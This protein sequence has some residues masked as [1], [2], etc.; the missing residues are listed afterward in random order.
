M[1]IYVVPNVP[2]TPTYG[3][4]GGVG[5][6]GFERNPLTGKVNRDPDT[7]KPVVALGKDA[8]DDLD[9]CFYRHDV[10]YQN[11]DDGLATRRDVLIADLKLIQE[12]TRLDPTSPGYPTDAYALAYMD[13]VK[14]AF[15]LKLI[16]D[17][18]RLDNLND[19]EIN[20][21]WNRCVKNYPNDWV[22]PL[23]DAHKTND[24][25]RDLFNTA[26]VTPSPIILDLD[27][28]GIETTSLTAGA[29]F[30]HDGNGFAEQT[31]W[32]SSDDGILVM[33]RNNNGTIDNGKE[34]FGDQTIL[35]NGARAANGF[36]ALAELD[37]N[38]DG[39]ID[40]NDAAFSN[41]KIWQDL[42]GDGYSA[43]DELFTLQEEGIQSI[44]TGYTLSS[45]VDAN[46]NE[47][48]QTGSFTK[49]DGTT[50]TATDVWFKADKMYTI[51]DEWLDVPDDIAALPDLQGYG[52]VYDLHQA[53]ARDTT[54]S[55]KSLIE[56]FAAE[57]DPVSRNSVMEAV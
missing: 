20:E 56:Q 43:S 17:M 1:S 36:Q 18:A 4:W 34:L 13:G 41:F 28:D 25:I 46:G 21:M 2:K 44:N 32:A 38:A 7:K 27:G 37:T 49:S 23:W 22:D 12:V 39:K 42:D 11:F 48:K 45:L 50:A 57:T 24:F 51:A 26:T 53:M 14:T 8:K 5:H 15:E 9:R 19:D 35:N 31:G 29:Y 54:G 52:N 30:D 10:V 55:L 47:H 40:A 3:N 33:D 16:Y 6:D